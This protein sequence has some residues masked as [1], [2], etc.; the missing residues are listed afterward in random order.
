MKRLVLLLFLTASC[1]RAGDKGVVVSVSPPASRAGEAVLAGGG[2]AVDAAVAVGFALAVTWPEAGNIGGGGFMLVRPAGARAEP[3]VFDYRETAPALARKDLFVKHGRKPYLTVGVPGS[4][5]GLGLAHGKFGKLPWK[6]VVAPAVKLAEEGFV[7]DEALAR[8]LNRALAKS[9]DFPELVRVFGQAGGK[10]RAGDRLVQKDLARTLRRL[11]EK[12]AAD[13]YQGETATLIDK[14]M[15]AGGGLVTKADLAGY[16]AKVRKPVHGTY[17]GYDVYVPPP[18]SSGGI[19]L[20]EMLNI[21]ETF[22]LKKGGRYSPRTLHL[23]AE[24]MRRAYCDRARYLG[25]QDFVKVP[26]QL[27]S[28]EYARKLAR[29]IDPARA[30]PSED[31]ARDVPLAE[32]KKHTTHYSVTDA[33][34]MAVSTTTTLEE[35]FG[36]KVV[37][38]GAGFLLNNEMTDFNTRPGVT[39]RS[40]LIGTA[41][42]QIE[43]GKRMLSSMTP[44]IVVK[45]GRPVLV[46]GSPG[47]RTIINT[48]LGVVLNVVEFGLPLREAVEAPRMH[49]QWF[50]DRIDLE[51]AFFEK[52]AGALEQLRKMGHRLRRVRDQGD[53]HSIW[54]D[55]RTGRY[56]GVADPRRAGH[57]AALKGGLKTAPRSPWRPPGPPPASPPARS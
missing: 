43:P 40:G 20:V 31:L 25:D 49:Q 13:F 51:P 2:N 30:T 44:T 47:G 22:D 57:G 45:G 4:V 53:A 24:A 5:A 33:A 55:P 14:E 3:V 19:C 23:M 28:K 52:Y 8:S 29:G 56:E 37:V 6:E 26:V 17:R 32:E 34:G 21:L 11:A 36:S 38:R 46:T 12:G 18:P 42:N 50:P 10:W 27:T 1:A 16:T 48:V 7:I 35:A 39:T 41:P 54:L 9:K 15:R